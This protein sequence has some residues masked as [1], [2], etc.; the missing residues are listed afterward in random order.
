M[1]ALALAELGNA[2]LAEA[3]QQCQKALASASLQL[4]D[5][6]EELTAEQRLWLIVISVALVI[7][8]G[9]MAGLTLGLLSLDR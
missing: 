6:E 2:S 9:L 4:H 5:G 8:A 3:L 7:F 1:S